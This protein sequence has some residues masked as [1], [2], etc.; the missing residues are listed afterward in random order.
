MFYVTFDPAT[1]LQQLHY[2]HVLSGESIPPTRPEVHF[3][4][5]GN[6]DWSVSPDGNVI[7]FQEARDNNLWL[8]EAG[9]EVAES[10]G[11]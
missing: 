3:F 1:D 2:Y 4:T 6:A 11:E 7:V 5:I 9:N 10:P 8:L